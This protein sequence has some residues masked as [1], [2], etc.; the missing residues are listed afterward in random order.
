MEGAEGAFF[1]SW[2]KGGQEGLTE[3]WGFVFPYFV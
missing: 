1:Q 2:V 3:G